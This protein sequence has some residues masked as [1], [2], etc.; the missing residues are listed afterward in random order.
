LNEKA[1]DPDFGRGLFLSKNLGLGLFRGNRRVTKEEMMKTAKE[2][3]DAVIAL[4]TDHKYD[5]EKI[6]VNSDVV[7]DISLEGVQTYGKEGHT[8]RFSAWLPLLAI[9]EL[10]NWCSWEIAEMTDYPEM[11]HDGDWSGVRDTNRE[12]IMEIFNTHVLPKIA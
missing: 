8:C 5:I 2:I 11:A 7:G 4:A 3:V 10:T 12:S 1:E 6:E 9:R